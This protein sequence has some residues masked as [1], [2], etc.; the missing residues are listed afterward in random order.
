MPPF[1]S[2]T[3]DV[4]PPTGDDAF[5]MESSDRFVG[6]KIIKTVEVV[7]QPSASDDLLATTT[8][9]SK[10]RANFVLSPSD[11]RTTSGTIVTTE[12][13]TR[14]DTFETQASQ[15]TRANIEAKPDI[16]F[17]IVLPN[18]RA[19]DTRGQE[20]GLVL[21]LSSKRLGSPDE[22]LRFLF[23]ESLVVA[24]VGPLGGG[25]RGRGPGRGFP[26]GGSAPPTGPVFAGGGDED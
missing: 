26:A 24:P 19:F 9:D 12:V 3:Q 8:T 14:I 25:G 23:R 22:P 10:G 20:L 11:I 2:K 15:S 16:Y 7:F 4:P 13:T 17:R 1:S 6:A 18:G 21:N 5:V